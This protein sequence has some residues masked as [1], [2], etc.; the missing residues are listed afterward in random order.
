MQSVT[1]VNPIKIQIQGDYWDSIL[2]KG[3]L[4]IWTMNGS[5]KVLDWDKMVDGLTDSIELNRTLE[6]AFKQG[7]FL[8]SGKNRALLYENENFRQEL[9]TSLE[10]IQSKSFVFEEKDLEKYIIRELDNPFNELP[11]D[12]DIYYDVIYTLLDNGLS[13]VDI[14]PDSSEAINKNTKEPLWDCPSFSL[15]IKG[16]RIALSAGEEG[17]FEY[18]INDIKVGKISE[19]DGQNITVNYKGLKEMKKNIR[20]MSEEPSLFS[21][22]SYSSIFS[23]SDYGDS[24]L[25]GFLSNKRGH[26]EYIES[27]S[28]STIFKKNKERNQLSWGSDD[29]IYREVEGGLEVVKFTQGKLL[30][31]NAFSRVEKIPFQPWKGKIL[32]AGMSF[33]GTIV[34]CENALVVLQSNNG[35]KNI[36]GPITK[37]RVFPRSIRYENQLHVITEDKLEIYSFNHDYFINQENKKYGIIKRNN[38]NSILYKK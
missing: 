29:K 14:V 27:F 36:E 13:K 37:W 6:C 2:Y 26:V 1:E 32:S 31:N 9:K 28:E 11:I 21:N 15:K 5:I 16:G 35:V 33:F 17:L 7:D 4:Y 23:S 34:E 24:T 30:Y 22:W 10:S 3:R 25:V 18:K 20:C 8:Y 12:L 38:F 19:E